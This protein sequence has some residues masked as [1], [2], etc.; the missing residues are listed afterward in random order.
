MIVGPLNSETIKEAADVIIKELKALAKEYGDKILKEIQIG[1][2]D[3]RKEL[4]KLAYPE[5]EKANILP[6]N[7]Q[8]LTKDKLVQTLKENTVPGSNEVAA[9]LRKD[10][11]KIYLYT[12][13]LKDREL[14]PVEKN[15]YIIFIS[16]AIARDLESLFDGKDLIVL[17]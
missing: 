15:K 11:S 17:N 4:K 1:Q 7:V 10:K 9:L 3:F 6:L 13:Y 5:L 12:A 14:I 8:F 16:D 2:F